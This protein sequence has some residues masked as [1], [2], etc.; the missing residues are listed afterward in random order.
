MNRTRTAR[1]GPR[2]RAR[3]T[4]AAA[5]GLA[6]AALSAGTASAE[7]QTGQGTG[8]SVRT[9]VL[10]YNDDLAP[11]LDAKIAQS[12]SIWNSA[13]EAVQLKEVDG[14]ADF[15]YVETD[16]SA[17]TDTDGHGQGQVFLPVGAPLR[18]VTHETGHILGL[19]DHFSGPCSELMSGGGPGPACTN[20]VPNASEAAQVDLLW[21]NG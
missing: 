1:P 21:A 11:S 15:S 13:V 6:L 10:T 18:V 9:V 3:R 19:P 2:I 8:Q 7:Q 16:G 17:H 12:T 5:L 14:A 20:A 4:A